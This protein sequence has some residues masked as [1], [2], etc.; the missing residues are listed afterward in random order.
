M[1]ISAHYSNVNLDEFNGALWARNHRDGIC[2]QTGAIG[3]AIRNNK[4]FL[5]MG[6]DRN[7]IMKESDGTL[8]ANRDL[9]YAR[10]M[11]YLEWARAHPELA[12]HPAPNRLSALAATATALATAG[13][14]SPPPADPCPPH[15]PGFIYTVERTVNISVYPLYY[16]YL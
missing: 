10:I 11:A 9:L 8:F 15:T 1:Q 3:A 2:T 14:A 6:P 12:W 4:D 13:T 7:A 5:R 16:I